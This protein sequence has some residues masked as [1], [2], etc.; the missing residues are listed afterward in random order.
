MSKKNGPPKISKKEFLARQARL[1][2]EMKE[3]RMD[4]VFMMGYD[5]RYMTGYDP[6]LET[7]AYA[8]F[9][10]GDK[11]LFPGP[12]CVTLAESQVKG[13]PRKN[14]VMTS[15][16][17]IGGEGYPYAEKKMKPLAEILG[18]YKKLKWGVVDPMG[19]S[20]GIYRSL[21]RALGGFADASDI[22]LDM[23]AVKS[24]AEIALMEYSYRLAGKAMIAGRKASKPGTTGA[25]VAR[26][27]ADVFWKGGVR[28]LSEIFMA[29]SGPETGPCL[30]FP[31]ERKIR[32]GELVILDV[33]GVYKG[34]Y[35][36]TART[37][38]A[39]DKIDKKAVEALNVAH[40]AREGAFEKIGPGVAGADVDK[41]A[42][43]I[44]ERRYKTAMTYQVAHS[45]GVAH[46]EPPHCQPVGPFKKLVCRP[47]MVFAMDVGMWSLKLGGGRFPSY[48]GGIRL[49]DGVLITKHGAKRLTPPQPDDPDRKV[50]HKN[51]R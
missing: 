38:I 22:L 10:N 17:M 45:V 4:A 9:I 41:V 46:C 30:N 20:A 33:G 23:R 50:E 7:V 48:E 26:V 2:K 19:L 43:K 31:S 42:R 39:G 14:I 21:K 6:L 34:Y 49:E 15:D 36:D 3:A 47:G 25:E 27:M 29:N 18:K 35:S 24:V 11:Y 8:Q 13:V 28:Q 16:T 51:Y 44:I 32:K 12:E 5:A 37:F 1:Q 40:E